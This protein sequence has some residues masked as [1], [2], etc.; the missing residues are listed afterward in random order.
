MAFGDTAGIVN[1]EFVRAMDGI[2]RSG[3]QTQFWFRLPEG[4]RIVS[5]HDQ[6][7]GCFHV[8]RRRA[9]EVWPSPSRD[10]CAHHFRAPRG[11]HKRRG[12]AGARAKVANVESAGA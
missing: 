9:S 7:R 12:R 2:E 3:R 6:Q 10:D 1:L 5:A 8:R 11:R 4:W